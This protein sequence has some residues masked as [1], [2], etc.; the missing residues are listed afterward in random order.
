MAYIIYKS[1]GSLFLTIE[2]GQ[3]DTS[4]TSLSLVGKNV[5]NYG[6]YETSN[7]IHLLENFA[8]NN[9]P[10]SPIEGQLWFDKTT[11]VLRLKV[12]SGQTWKSLPNFVFSTSTTTLNPG[13]FW[14]KTDSEELYIQSTLTTA[15]IGGPNIVAKSATRLATLRNINGV[16]FDGSEDIT[17]SATLTNSLVFGNYVIGASAFNGTATTTIA[18]DTGDVAQPVPGKVVARDTSGDIWFRVGHGT[19]TA[20][21]YA[22]LAEKYLADRDY[23]TGT[24]LTVGGTAEVTECSYGDR[25]IGV[26]SENPGFMMNKDLENGTYVALKGRVP[27]KVFGEVKK[28]QRLV[29]GPNGRAV[30]ISSP[31]ADVFAIA[32]EDSNGRDVV[33]SLIL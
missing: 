22:D 15:L 29:A 1:D 31:N 3:V 14:W 17:I 23:E 12:Y 33:E 24:V 27:V 10:N 25:A 21:R 20:A 32:L 11:D 8:N 13:D 2:D 7:Y 19:A 26:V 16:P 30:P 18:V 28:S 4:N 9:P 6:Q 5:I